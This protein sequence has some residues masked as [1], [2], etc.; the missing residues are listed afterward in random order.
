MAW[1]ILMPSSDFAF[2]AASRTAW[3]GHVC[4]PVPRR[5]LLAEH[6]RDRVDERLHRRHVRLVPTTIPA[7]T[8]RPA[9]FRHR[10]YALQLEQ[11]AAELHLLIHAELHE[12]LHAIDLRGAAHVVQQHVGL[13]G[14]G[15]DQR[16]RKVR[17]RDRQHV[18][19]ELAAGGFQLLDEVVLQR[20][21]IGVVRRD[22]EPFLPK[23]L[24]SSV[25]HRC[26]VHRG[27]IAGAVGVPLAVGA[28]DRIGMPA[29]ND[30]DTPRLT[31]R[32]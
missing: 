2:S 23:R 16:G 29:G 27:R 18:G 3:I 28:G 25:D 10:A 20:V 17:G 5:G 12:L 19:L 6:G 8:S 15:L 14:L 9:P 30:V 11:R 21:A 32:P 24:S 26:G 1:A 13:V 4:H 31:S 7:P 22:E